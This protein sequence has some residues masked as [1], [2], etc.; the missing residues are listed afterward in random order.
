MADQPTLHEPARTEHVG[1]TG[2]YPASGPPPP[3]SMPPIR[4]QGALAH[5]EERT[6]A[7]GHDSATQATLAIGRLLFGG[8]FLF[9]GINHFVK[10]GMLVQYAG[11]KGAPN[12]ELAVTG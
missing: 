1:H 2:I 10:R 9:N 5:P 4:G 12:P 6:A 11:S 3:S 8:Y 7:A